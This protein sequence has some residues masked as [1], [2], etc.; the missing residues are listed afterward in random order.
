MDSKVR[1]FPPHLPKEADFAMPKGRCP[2]ELVYFSEGL[3]QY[4]KYY[5]SLHPL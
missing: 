3:L 4:V 5:N 2:A 1:I